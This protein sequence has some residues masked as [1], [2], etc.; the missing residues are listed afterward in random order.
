MSQAVIE[1]NQLTKDYGNGR[2]CRQITLSVGAGE[3]FGFLGPNGA[4]KSTFVKMLVGL[5]QPTSG[6][7]TLFGEPIGS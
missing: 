2:G 7:G 3:A 5:I 4:G 6:K 1:T